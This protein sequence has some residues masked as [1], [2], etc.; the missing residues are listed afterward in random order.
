MGYLEIS[1]YFEIFIDDYEMH[2]KFN[3]VIGE[4]EIEQKLTSI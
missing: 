2:V 3:S 4:K 1:N